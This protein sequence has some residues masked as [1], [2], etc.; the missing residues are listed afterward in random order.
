MSMMMT[1]VINDLRIDN[2]PNDCRLV[3]SIH[4][5]FGESSH[6]MSH[7][8]PLLIFPLLPQDQ[9]GQLPHGVGSGGESRQPQ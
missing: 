8:D 9:C 6:L 2:L 3:I 5:S 7:A 1:K 4:P